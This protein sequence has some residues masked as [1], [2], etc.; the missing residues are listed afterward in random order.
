MNHVLDDYI[1]NNYVVIGVSAGPDSMCLLDLL[2]KKTT[3]IVVCH[4][5]HNVRKESI[6][7]EEYITKYCQDKNIILEKTTINNYQENNFENE[8]RKK[9]YM[10]YEEILKKYNSKTLLLAHHGD[11]LIETI[12]M[13]ISRGSNLDGYA[14]IKEISNVKNY[15]I[16]RPLLKY[17]KEDI[18]NYNKSNNIKYY[19]DSSNQST[20]YTRNRYRLNILPLLKKEDK[21]I[22]K[23]YLKYSKTLIEYDDYIKREV[24]RNI[25]NV[26]KD[27]II[28]IDNLNKL[29]TFLIKNILYNIMNNIYQNKNNIITDRHIQNIISLLNNTKPNIKIDL[30]NNKEIVKEYNKLIIKD[31]TS[32]IKNY[33]IEFNDKIETE[34]LIIEKIESEDDDSNSVCRLNSKDIT[35]PLY[36][37]N[38]E[39]G[40]YIILKGSNNR[41]KIKEIF[42]EKK[43]PLKKRNNYPLL[44]DSNNN[45]IWIPNIKKSKFCNKKSENYD[46]IIRCNERKEDYE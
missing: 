17:T 14:G 2:Q 22:H 28:N 13:K 4:I 46:I 8:A 40:D 33:K 5:N 3:K 27:N 43:L 24:K 26:Y 34:N 32:D 7:E 11:D 15:Q 19:N 18:I 31:K 38:R 20:N 39:D 41:K 37:R 23:K 36:I 35:L 42:I 45:I 44:V 1:F 25:N 12:L 6:E 21:N 9:R 10:F 29:D 30:P 16:I